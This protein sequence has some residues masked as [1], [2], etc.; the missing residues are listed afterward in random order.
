MISDT[1]ITK[2]KLATDL[3]EL[4]QEYGAKLYPAGEN[5]WQGRCPHPDHNDATP[6]F[7]IWLKPGN[8]WTWACMGCHSG[9]KDL[10]HGNYGS[11]CFAFV[12]WMSSHSHSKHRLS[13]YETVQLLADRAGIP[14]EED[15][16]SWEIS[17]NNLKAKAYHSG[18]PNY[19]R[20]YLTRRGLSDTDIKEW[21][22]G[23]TCF[24]EKTAGYKAVPRISFP[25]FSNHRQILGFSSRKLE[26]NIDE[27]VPKYRNS[28]N[29]PWFSK[30][31]YLYGNH[32]YDS[33][34]C[35]IRIVEGVMD[36]ILATK[37]GAKNV[38]APLGTSFTAEQAE[39]IKNT[40]KIPVLCMDGD[41]AGQHAIKRIV[42]M[43]ANIGVYCK[44]LILPNNMDMADIANEQKD[45]LENYIQTHALLYWQYMLKD[46]IAEYES[47]L[48]ELRMNILP[49]IKLAAEGIKTQEEKI[50]L[51]SF[52][53]ERLGVYLE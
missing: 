45:N 26:D 42:S 25:L 53:K 23:F 6:S 22:I 39:L 40:R 20:K 50:M 24:P 10:K 9:K 16:Y 18:L 21:L 13:F 36:V 52:I 41:A 17:Q 37:Y 28:A 46:I 1:I 33:S 2:V 14:L 15:K 47:K 19:V 31:S 29:S 48:S 5:I 3:K 35:E 34:F 30:R 27:N 7:R 43:F 12:Q 44:I 8:D 32:K 38:V 49:A 51:N 11:D 4:A